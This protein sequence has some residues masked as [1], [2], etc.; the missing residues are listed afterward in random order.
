MMT[1][2]TSHPILQQDGDLKTFLESEN[3][4]VD[5]KHKEKKEFGISESKGGVLSSIGLSGSTN[6]K[7]I[8]HDDVSCSPTHFRLRY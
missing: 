7:F 2:I 8:E 4:T 1:K 5:I 3:F 6:T